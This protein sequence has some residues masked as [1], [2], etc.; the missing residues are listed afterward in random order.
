[1]ELELAQA[2]LGVQEALA[3]LAARRGT[4]RLAERTHHLA[5]VRWQNGL[6]TQLEVST[7]RLR[8][9]NTQA[10]EVQA[11]KDYR[12]S[13]ARL[14]RAAGKAVPTTERSLDDLSYDPTPKPESKP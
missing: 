12:L 10:N 3:T 6:S 13:L 4:A 7:A 2:R 1:V 5:V 14:D 9:Q 8:M 11:L